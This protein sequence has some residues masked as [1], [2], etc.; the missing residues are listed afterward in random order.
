MSNIVKKGD[1]K[2]NIWYNI[3]D[4]ILARMRI[5]RT[6]CEAYSIIFKYIT[7]GA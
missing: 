1:Y 5:G 7:P 3:A 2:K 4:I 6:I